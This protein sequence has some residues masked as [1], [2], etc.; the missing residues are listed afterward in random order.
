M[1]EISGLVNTVGTNGSPVLQHALSIGRGG[2]VV[3]AA[4]ALSSIVSSA[5]ED[6]PRG[7]ATNKKAAP[8]KKN[9]AVA[10]KKSPKTTAE[11]WIGPR[12][13]AV[14]F[15][16]VAMSLHYLG[17]SLARPITI[18]LFTSETSGYGKYAAAFPFA[19]AFVSPMSLGLLLG[20]GRVL[21]QHGP[22]G[23]LI[24]S[25]IFCATVVSASAI[26]INLFE[27][28]GTLIMKVPAAKFVSG[29]LFVFRESYV[30]LLTTQYWSFMASALTPT[31]SA[32][33]FGPIAGLTSITSA[34]AGFAV[35]DIIDSIGISFSLLGTGV[36]LLVSIFAA[37]MAYAISEEH[38]FSPVAKKHGS[39]N[40]QQ[41][42]QMGMFEKAAKLFARVPVL[43]KLFI[44]ILASQGL[45]T[46]LNVAF[47]ARLARSIPNDAERAGWVGKFFSTINVISMVLQFGILPPLLSIVEPRIMWR[48]VPFIAMMF[49]SFQASQPDP[50]LYIVSATLLV[51][52]VL[53]YS[54]RRML[55]EMVY[56]P[57]DFESRFV[58]KE[59]IGV[60]G[61]RFGKSLM[62]L[63]LSGITALFGDMG[64]Q[65]YSILGAGINVLWF[66]AS[67]SLSN[68]VPTR[69]EAEEIYQQQR[70]KKRGGG[71]R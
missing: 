24:R 34:I 30:Q 38:G 19:M 60:F 32:K 35:S 55:D 4:S 13:K 27:A 5:V 45:A 63:G 46:I 47:V 51:M 66:W 31:Q 6:L 49:T 52:K 22:R 64:I 36:T 33:W 41:E 40:K 1:L 56:V 29:P 57:L 15:M 42:Q 65:E 10:V 58:G 37:N 62:S 12:G 26:A 20:Y 14:F 48:I 25:T 21:D 18:S 53:E 17:Y 43:L 61:Y 71:K 9:K 2:A 67:W 16:A 54:A 7:G 68:E 70:S 39:N 8:S 44:E 23:A 59:V 28:Y 50:T 3:V 11:S 69:K